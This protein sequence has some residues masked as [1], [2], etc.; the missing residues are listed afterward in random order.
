MGINSGARKR[1]P[2]EIVSAAEAHRRPT[3]P[4]AVRGA[5]AFSGTSDTDYVCGRCGVVICEG[6]RPG[7]F[8][9]FVFQCSCGQFNRVPSLG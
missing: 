3:P 6:V 7:A 5:P 8:A 2:L 9:G 4:I 1:V